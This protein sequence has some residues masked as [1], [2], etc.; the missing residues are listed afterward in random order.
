LAEGGLLALVLALGCFGQL[1][2]ELSA[3]ARS[4]PADIR[5][6]SASALAVVASIAFQGLFEAAFLWDFPT[7]AALGLA[8]AVVG[9]PRAAPS[10]RESESAQQPSEQG[11]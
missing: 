4:Q 11:V 2:R 7:W 3:R 5:I 10:Q 1:G 8:T 9:L 6:V